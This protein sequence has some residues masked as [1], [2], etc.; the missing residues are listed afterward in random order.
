MNYNNKKKTFFITCLIAGVLFATSCIP[1]TATS[2]N[3]KDDEIAHYIMNQLSYTDNQNILCYLWGPVSAG[4]KIQ[5]TKGP[6]FTAPSQGYVMYIDP[7]PQK[8]LFHPVQYVF[9]TEETREL[10]V[11]DAVSPPLNFNDYHVV[12]T[13]FAQFFY[14]VENRRASIPAGTQPN[15]DKNVGD[16][17][18]VVLMNGGYDSGNNH[19]RYWNDLSN[20]YITLNTVYQIPDENIIVLCSD[21]LNPAVD[22][23]NGQNSNPDLDGD[24]DADI[25]YSCVLSNVDM[26]FANLAANASEIDKLFVFTTDHG[27]P[28]SGWDVIENLWNYEE[29]SDAHFASLLAAF[30]DTEIICTLEP[31]NSGGFLDNVVVLPGPVVCTSAC[32]YDESSWAMAPDYV[33]DEYVFYWTA[34]VKGQDA[35]GNPVNADA[36]QDGIITMDE[37]YAYAIDHDTASE[38]PQYGEY[39]E[40]TGAQLSLWVSSA[41][42]AQPSKPA[43][44]ALGIWNVNYS[45]TSSTTEPDNEQIYYLFDWGDG[46]NSGWLGPY[47]SGQT[48]TAH[49]IWTVLGTF[50]VKVKARDIHGSG[51]SWSDP[52]AVTITDNTPPDIPEITGPAE[53]KPGSPYLYNLRSVDAQGQNIYFFIDWGDNTTSGWLGPYVTG[54]QIHV[55]HIW[56]IKGTYNVKVKAKDSMDSES[57]WGNLSVTMPYKFMGPMNPFLEKL[58][59]RFPNAFP[60]IRHFL[61]F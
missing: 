2:P 56:S 22:Q 42:P 35:Y 36:N 54:T 8:N 27:G 38:S 23:S 32:R 26:V 48:G 59:E 16:G 52:L 17:R 25:M 6:V 24:G 33:Y 49:H 39:P 4:E 61:G 45:Y 13:A 50:S 51:S 55:T 14:S 43:G 15:N 34:A 28:V 47:S 10:T 20:I 41:P 18:W 30:P 5:A 3:A 29:L 60:I 7:Y 1:L 11:F 46:S 44:P 9:L 57:A 21:G 40:G 19:V 58:F 37:A 53:G 12:H 31:C